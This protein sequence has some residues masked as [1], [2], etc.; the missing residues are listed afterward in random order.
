MTGLDNQVVWG[1]PHVFAVFLIVAASGALNVASLASVFGR[2]EYRPLAPLSAWLAIALLAGGLAVLALDLGRPERI[3]VA[4][5]HY[6]LRSIFALNMFL[7]SVF[8]AL[9]ALY[10][11]TLLERRAARHSSIVGAAA[12]AWRV[13]LTTGTG[14]IFGFLVAREAYASAL[15]APLFIAY[16]LVYGTAVYLVA[17]IALSREEKALPALA[18]LLG[19]F[20]VAA[21]YLV[22]VFHLANLYVAKQ[23]AVTSF[24]LWEGGLYPLLFWGGQ[25]G[26]GALMPLAMLWHPRLGGSRGPVL[27]AALLVVAGGLAQMYVTIV[28][29]QAWPLD[30]VPG[31]EA[32]S[33]FFDGEIHRHVPSLHDIV[34]AVTGFAL[35][36]LIVLL[37]VRLL[38]I[39][40]ARA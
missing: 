26:L 25:V 11:Y 40:P 15:L 6:N 35:A 16:S 14:L 9:A 28:G 19:W 3:V 36:A 12:F 1:L 27:A 5:T 8:I 29:A 23:A 18:R 38:R 24:L 2:T 10:L 4:M 31:F 7:Y 22:A 17:L 13:A 32:R 33:S 34:L 20:L 39:L 21:L 37:G 30:L